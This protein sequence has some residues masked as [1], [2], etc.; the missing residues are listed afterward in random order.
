MNR[1]KPVVSVVLST[2]NRAYLLRQTLLG[3]ERQSASCDWEVVVIDNGSTD[4]TP[5]VL[6]SMSERLPLRILKE[7]RPGKSRGINLAM[8]IAGGEL[9]IFTDD[10][11]RPSPLWAAEYQLASRQYPKVDIFCGPINNLFPAGAPE[12][13]ANC[14]HASPLFAKFAPRATKGELSP[15]VLP[16]GGNFAVR[17]Q[18]LHGM[19]L[20]ERLGPPHK[21]MGEDTDFLLR[22]KAR[23]PHILYVPGAAV[24]HC[25]RAEQ[26]R[27]PAIF[28]RAFTCGTSMIAVMNTLDI[29][30]SLPD[31]DIP[32]AGEFNLGV[33]LNYSYGQLYQLT[34]RGGDSREAILTSHI[35]ALNWSGE[36]ELL[37]ARARSWLLEN[38][39]QVPTEARQS[40]EKCLELEYQE[41]ALGS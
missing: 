12:W 14:P 28:D 11:I 34:Q 31:S 23:S 21:I 35:A 32:A 4:R 13:L 26:L 36:P 16:F 5:D 9:V 22:L 30:P 27:L 33:D 15:D 29:V 8:A 17:R 41:L 24:D 10:D 7:S 6:A 1:T 3:M 18:L 19:Q 20:D 38:P 2:Y 40:F 37:S 25:I 39:H